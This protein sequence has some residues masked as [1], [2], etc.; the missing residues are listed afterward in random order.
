MSL[1]Q[2]GVALEPSLSHRRCSETDRS[3]ARVSMRGCA[4]VCSCCPLLSF[5]TTLPGPASSR[6]P[7]AASP[8]LSL[9]PARQDT[10]ERRDM[11]ASVLDHSPSALPCCRWK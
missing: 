7:P 5:S 6:S 8:H 3:P 10:H 9:D 2:D 4:L 1:F 11:P